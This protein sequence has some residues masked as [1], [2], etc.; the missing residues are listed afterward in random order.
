MTAI[1]RRDDVPDAERCGCER[2]LRWLALV[3][4]VLRIVAL[5][6]SI[7]TALQAP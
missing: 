6:A 3:K 7:W 2:R 5:I 4:R 1:D